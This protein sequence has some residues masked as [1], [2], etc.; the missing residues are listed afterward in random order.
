M[1]ALYDGTGVGRCWPILTGERR[2]HYELAA[3]RDPKRFI[4][5]MENFSNQGGMITEQVW[6]ADD[7]PHARMKC[8]R[9]TGAAMPLC[10][11]HAGI[12]YARRQ[13]PGMTAF[14]SIAQ[15]RCTKCFTCGHPNPE[16]IRN[17]E[18]ASSLAACVA[19]QDFANH[20]RRA[21]PRIV[22]SMDNWARTT[23]SDMIHLDELNLWFADFPRKTGPSAPCL[24]LQFF[25]N[26]INA[27]RAKT[28]K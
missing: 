23:K 28:G 18:S 17:L 5:T 26:A 19:R 6:D 27:G 21:R 20:P 2:G 4:T 13:Q 14:A 1:A 16:P 9:P 7:L 10:W 22:W 24:H 25:G 15:A 11:S 12:C 8:G 3:G